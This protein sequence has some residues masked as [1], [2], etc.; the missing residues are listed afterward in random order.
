MCS[1]RTRDNHTLVALLLPSQ[2]R[3]VEIDLGEFVADECL[4]ANMA[5]SKLVSLGDG[6]DADAIYDA[7]LRGIR[8]ESGGSA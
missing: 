7:E 1:M 4:A 2:T 6:N 8:H 5:I 3:E